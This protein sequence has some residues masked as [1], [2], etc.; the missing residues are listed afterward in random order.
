[1]AGTVILL[2]L[3]YMIEMMWIGMASILVGGKEGQNVTAW[4]WKWIPFLGSIGNPELK[5]K[6]RLINGCYQ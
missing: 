2:M 5:H 6:K 1:M 4:C 3:I